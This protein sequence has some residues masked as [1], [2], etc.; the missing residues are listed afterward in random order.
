MV[1][2]PFFHGFPM[3]S[4]WFPHGFHGAQTPEALAKPPRRRSHLRPTAEHCDWWLPMDASCGA[5]CR[6]YGITQGGLTYQLMKTEDLTSIFNFQNRGFQQESGSHLQSRFIW[7]RLPAEVDL[8]KKRWD[9]AVGSQ[10]L[11]WFYSILEM[12]VWPGNAV[13][14]DFLKSATQDALRQVEGGE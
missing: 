12:I 13:L 4:L 10:N 2:S 7:P 6:C 3:V 9:N 8:M 5:G 1:K 14:C 11:V